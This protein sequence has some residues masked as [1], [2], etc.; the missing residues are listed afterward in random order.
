MSHISAIIPFRTKKSTLECNLRK[1]NDINE[2]QREIVK[3]ITPFLSLYHYPSYLKVS[4]RKLKT[5]P[6][7]RSENFDFCI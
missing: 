4:K 1:K 3:F 7:W 5:C 2:L 6:D